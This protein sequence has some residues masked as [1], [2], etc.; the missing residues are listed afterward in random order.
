MFR[1][2][3]RRA[4]GSLLG[5]NSLQMHMNRRLM[6]MSSVELRNT[7]QSLYEDVFRIWYD[8]KAID[9]SSAQ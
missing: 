7:L 2:G 1:V 3:L 6:S 4:G 5:I 9:Y 8:Y